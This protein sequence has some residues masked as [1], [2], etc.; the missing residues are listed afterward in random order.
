MASPPKPSTGKPAEP[1]GDWAD[2]A[3][4]LQLEDD[5]DVARSAEPAAVAATPAGGKV[6]V[7]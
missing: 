6:N 3:Q 5:G 1:V 4:R 2:T 7:Q